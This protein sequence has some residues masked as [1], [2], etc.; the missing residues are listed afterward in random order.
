MNVNH[1]DIVSIDFETLSLADILGSDGVSDFLQRLTQSPI[2]LTIRGTLHRAG[3]AGFYHWHE[4]HRE[5]L[6][7]DERDFRYAPVKRKMSLG[8]ADICSFMASEKGSSIVLQEQRDRWL[9]DFRPQ[10][11]SISLNGDYLA[12][13]VQEFC[14]WAGLGKFYR[15]KIDC[16][17]N[18]ADK[19]CQIILFK[20]PLDD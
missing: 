8:L 14:S 5:R 9:L 18:S 13:F 16:D 20:D 1:S 2:D 4:Q 7:W 11:G 3:R 10:P 19:T 15:V 17:E 6:G 12:G